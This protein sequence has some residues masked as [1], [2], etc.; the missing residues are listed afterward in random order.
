[1]SRRDAVAIPAVPRKTLLEWIDDDGDTSSLSQP[2]CDPK[3][4][5]LHAKVLAALGGVGAYEPLQPPAG[6]RL[7]PLG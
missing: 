1:M 7:A 4:Q 6:L 5:A 3:V 2:A